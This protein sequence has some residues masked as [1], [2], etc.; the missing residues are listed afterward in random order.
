VKQTELKR[1]PGPKRKSPPKQSQP[2]REWKW[3]RAK[4]EAEGVCRMNG[5]HGQCLGKLEAAHIIGREHDYPVPVIGGMGAISHYEVQP[6]AVV[7]LCTKHHKAYDAHEVD[8][9]PHLTLDEQMQAVKDAGGLELARRRT[10]PLA[11][12]DERDAA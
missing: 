4:V 5:R 6:F 8:L 10:A 11:Y 1:G 3:A 7:P 12:R 9:L 2:R